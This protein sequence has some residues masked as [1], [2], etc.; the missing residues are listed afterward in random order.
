MEYPLDRDKFKQLIKGLRTT[1]PSD[2]FIPNEEAANIWYRCL[3][4]LPYEALANG[5]SKW[6]MTSSKEPTVA[7]LRKAAMEFIP[8]PAPELNEQQACALVR[9]AVRASGWH[10][11]EE[12]D[13]LPEICQKAVGSPENLEEWSQMDIDSFESVQMSQFLR[14]FRVVQ[15]REQEV[16]Q[17]SPAVQKRLAL[18]MSE[19]PEIPKKEPEKIEEQH[20]EGIPM[21]DSAKKRLEE[22]EKKW[23]AG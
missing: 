14:N 15:N 10:A 8:K 9:K 17:L 2:W 22:I 5:V 11:K 13:K 18:A 16:A 1:Y 21:P 7:D 3:M 12:F 6:I 23:K 19:A 4:D 20:V